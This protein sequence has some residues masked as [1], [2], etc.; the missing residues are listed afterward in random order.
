[1]ISASIGI[2][3]MNSDSDDCPVTDDADL[4]SDDP[5]VFGRVV[6]RYQRSLFGFFGR[7]GFSQTDTE[8]LAQDTFL[9]AWRH[10][11][12]YDA[13]RSRVSTWL[14]AIAR[15]LARDELDRRT[16]RPSGGDDLPE[17][18]DSR[19]GVDPVACVETNQRIERLRAGLQALSSDDRALIALSFTDELSADEA[20]GLLGCTVGTFRTRLSRAR[21]R[22]LAACG[23]EESR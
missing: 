9:R 23:T 21:Q 15:N 16:R 5:T 13:R 8:E 10:R 2:T 6:T 14:F 1:M 3:G 18:V 20:A 11:A 4:T 17:L 12:R 22:L 19:L 7:M